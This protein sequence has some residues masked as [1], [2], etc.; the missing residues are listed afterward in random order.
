[1]LVAFAAE[2]AQAGDA[3]EAGE[4]I[5]SARAKLARKRADLIV[6]NL[7]GV[8]RVFGA[9]RNSATVLGP[10]GVV[11]ELGEQAKEDLADAVL[12]LVVSADQGG[13]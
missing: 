13:S 3:G 7:V 4:A 10:H 11:A 8:D 5:A 1:V 2:T 9:D 12:S 6:L